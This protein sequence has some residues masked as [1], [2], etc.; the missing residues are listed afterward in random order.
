[1]SL[2]L[3]L[4]QGAKI[5]TNFAPYIFTAQTQDLKTWS[6]GKKLDVTGLTPADSY[7]DM[8]VIY[9]SSDKATPYHGFMKNEVEKYIEHLAAS[10][11]FGPWEFV[12]K[13]DFANWGIKEGPAVVQKEDGSWRMW[14]DDYHGHV[15]YADSDDLY[16][17]GKMVDIPDGVAR[18]VRHGTF[19]RQTVD[20]AVIT[21]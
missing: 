20:P 9:N 8:F 21:P 14:A 7:I 18:K 10:S 15:K 5:K 19:L 4:P 13:G 1:V 6:I 2:R 17:W 11:I 12:Q 3:D 16:N